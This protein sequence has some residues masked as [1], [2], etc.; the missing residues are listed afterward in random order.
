[1]TVHLR[2]HSYFSGTVG[3]RNEHR[4]CTRLRCSS[5]AVCECA[6][7]AR[8]GYITAA[9]LLLSRAI[10]R[11]RY[12]ARQTG[13]SLPVRAESGRDSARRRG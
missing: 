8:L 6:M 5:L 10:L 12:G 11:P 1:M 4:V 13:R 7:R 2:S 9:R 3:T